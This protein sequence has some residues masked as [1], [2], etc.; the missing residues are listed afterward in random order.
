MR[1]QEVSTARLAH[2]SYEA[3]AQDFG[4]PPERFIDEN[5]LWGLLSA[6]GVGVGVTWSGDGQARQFAELGD[7][8]EEFR[9]VDAAALLIK[10]PDL[11]KEHRDLD[12]L[13]PEGF[14]AVHQLLLNRGYRV[15][16]DGEPYK[17]GYA[18]EA[19]GQ[20]FDLD[21]HEAVSWWGN[22]YLDARTVWAE[23]TDRRMHGVR[24]PVPSPEHELLICA[25][26]AAFGEVRLNL[27]D[28]IT[29]WWLTQQGV[30][31]PQARE[32][33]AQ[34]GWRSQFDYVCGLME[35][36]HRELF[37]DPLQLGDAMLAPSPIPSLPYR[38]PIGRIGGLRLAKTRADLADHGIQRAAGTARGFVL[39]SAQLGLDYFFYRTGLPKHWAFNLRSLLSEANR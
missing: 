17:R 5:R 23:R 9:E 34:Q 32:V 7:L 10:Y 31:V 2:P 28:V 26:N 22:T 12:L 33:A 35:A 4:S 3:D 15:T 6:R 25:A 30:D 14:D 19:S 29:A 38:Y 11:P 1:P 18:R 39:E 20:E 36:V 8:L 37:D 13:I 16:G 27:F 24:V 21:V